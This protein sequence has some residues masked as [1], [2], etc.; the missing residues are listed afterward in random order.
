MKDAV[1]ASVSVM[2]H[3]HT[4]V[5]CACEIGP[6][7]PYVPFW[8]KVDRRFYGLKPNILV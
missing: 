4:A 6:S 7:S 1:P 5:V 2:G 8:A 3:K